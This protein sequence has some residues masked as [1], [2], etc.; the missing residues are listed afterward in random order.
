MI[1]LAW[2]DSNA[3]WPTRFRK[4]GGRVIMENEQVVAFTES[5]G[6]GMKR[7]GGS[8]QG[9]LSSGHRPY[10]KIRSSRVTDEMLD[11]R[12]GELKDRLS[13]GS[14]L[15]MP[16]LPMV[17]RTRCSLHFWGN[18]ERKQSQILR[19]STC[20][21]ALCVPCFSLFHTCIEVKEL[22]K[23]FQGKLPPTIVKQAMNQ[24]NF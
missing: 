10:R 2:M 17:K 3:N 7:K 4:R 1:T 11:P 14:G 13:V 8:S 16:V 5:E 21:I 24:M 19:C 15:H 9:S 23:H 18:Q 20:D 12:I 22:R 6:G